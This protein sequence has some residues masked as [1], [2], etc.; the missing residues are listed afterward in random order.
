MTRPLV[1]PRVP[2]LEWY[3][4]DRTLAEWE[5]ALENISNRVVLRHG[6]G[7]KVQRRLFAGLPELEENLSDLIRD[8]VDRLPRTNTNQ[9]ELVDFPHD[10]IT[11]NV[12][13]LVRSPNF[14]QKHDNLSA[15]PSDAEKTLESFGRM[16]A[17]FCKI[18][19]E[20]NVVDSYTYRNLLKKRDVPTATEKIVRYLSKMPGQVVLHG[21]DPTIRLRSDDTVASVESREAL[22][23][24]LHKAGIEPKFYKLDAHKRGNDG[25]VVFPHVRYLEFVFDGGNPIVLALDQ[26]LDTF[27]RPGVHTA[28]EQLTDE[29][30]KEWHKAKRILTVLRIDDRFDGI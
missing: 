4:P 17:T 27:G 8:K 1:S 22:K 12:F 14:K 25:T 16:F 11:G 26:G 2:V 6:W 21:P 24:E 13:E 10:S 28:Q 15:P 18:A 29:E 23:L 5:S 3:Y 20:I 7:E 30:V 9:E 19:T